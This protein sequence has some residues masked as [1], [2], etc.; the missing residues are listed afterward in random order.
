MSTASAPKSAA[1]SQAGVTV[2]LGWFDR[3]FTSR[4]R[5]ATLLR[6]YYEAGML[7]KQ[8]YDHALRTLGEGQSLISPITYAIGAGTGAGAYARI[9]ARP[10]WGIAATMITSALACTAGS[11]WGISQ[12]PAARFM[13]GARDRAAVKRVLVDLAQRG[14][15]ASAT[16]EVKSDDWEIG[17][18]AAPGSSWEDT[19]PTEPKA[20]TRSAFPSSSPSPAPPVHN[21]TS[22]P[23]NKWDGIRA[24]NAGPTKPSTWDILRQQHERPRVPVPD[25]NPSPSTDDPDNSISSDPWGSQSRPAGTS[26]LGA[27]AEA[28]RMA[29]QARFDAMLEAERRRSAGS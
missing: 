6:P 26:E 21:N 22:R 7:S 1:D 19:I 2:D 15:G 11:A 12:L 13:S 27:R 14:D 24:A 10:R 8:D 17:Q 29:E 25:S 4:E 9:F 5:T 18:R 23:P 28:E 16:E 20:S 3:T